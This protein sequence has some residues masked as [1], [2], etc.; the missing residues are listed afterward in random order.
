M[1]ISPPTSVG[2][3]II[4]CSNE[5]LCP[6]CFPLI[7]IL[8]RYLECFFFFLKLNFLTLCSYL[9]LMILDAIITKSIFLH[10]AC[11]QSE[12]DLSVSVFFS[13]HSCPHTCSAILKTVSPSSGIGELHAKKIKK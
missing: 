3:I 6:H 2:A 5:C 11:P 8:Q 13:S 9:K 12:S 4:M 10:L 7:I 1:I